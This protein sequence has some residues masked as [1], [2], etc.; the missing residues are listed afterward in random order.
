LR[1]CIAASGGLR[2][3]ADILRWDAQ[4]LLHGAPRFGL[5]RK[6]EQRAR[7]NDEGYAS[8]DRIQPDRRRTAPT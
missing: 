6:P 7:D 5:A 8:K 3:D 1:R 4:L 2:L